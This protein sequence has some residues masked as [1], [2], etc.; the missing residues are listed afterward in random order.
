MKSPR[1]VTLL[2][3]M[4]MAAPA[5]A[6]LAMP[7]PPAPT[8]GTAAAPLLP[9][10]GEVLS[11]VEKA[12]APAAGQAAGDWAAPVKLAVVF[13]LLAL[14]PSVLVMMTSFTRIVIVLGFIRR[15]LKYAAASMDAPSVV[16]KGPDLVCE[17]IKEIARAHNVPVIE[18]PELARALYATVEIGQPVPEALFVA[19]AEVMAMIYRLRAR[20]GNVIRRSQP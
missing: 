19:V 16:A 9:G 20:S 10:M 13:T 11:A 8:A 17:K 18:R 4:A 15:A 6:Q 3:A 14:L 2:V 1:L 12:T 5:P 7:S